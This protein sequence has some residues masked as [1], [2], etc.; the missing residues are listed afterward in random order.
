MKYDMELR[1]VEITFFCYLIDKIKSL[2]GNLSSI[3]LI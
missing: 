3:N 1:K 2:E